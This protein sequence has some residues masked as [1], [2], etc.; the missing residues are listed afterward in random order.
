MPERDPSAAVLRARCRF[1]V[2]L[3][4]AAA[5]ALAQAACASAAISVT[6]PGS[7]ILVARN[8]GTHAKTVGFATSSFLSPNGKLVALRGGDHCAP[9]SPMQIVDVASGASVQAHGFYLGCM[10]NHPAWSHDSKTLYS[11]RVDDRDG[12]NPRLVSVNAATGVETVLPSGNGRV[13]GWDVSLSPDGTRL[14]FVV[15]LST[16]GSLA[17]HTALRVLNLHSRK[18]QTLRTG[19]LLS[20]VFGP[21]KIAFAVSRGTPATGFTVDTAVIGQNGG[22]YRVLTHARANRSFTPI[23][24]SANGARLLGATT[25]GSVAINPRTGAVR[26]LSRTIRAA[27]LASSGRFMLGYSDS[28]SGINPGNT[29]RIA[30]ARGGARRLLFRHATFPSL[31]R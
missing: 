3:I 22:G 20:P 17:F 28:G 2:A 19:K 5:A 8:D 6:R 13:T 16:P 9:T 7:R 14:A 31:S 21:T 26:T 12:A 18:L 23:G 10:P 27:V 1:G 25:T 30:W 24:F 29:W 15:D 11:V 4:A